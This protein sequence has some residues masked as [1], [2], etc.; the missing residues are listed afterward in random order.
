MTV[1][2]ASLKG[3]SSQK[4]TIVCIVVLFVSIF[5]NNFLVW[6]EYFCK[7]AAAAQGKSNNNPYLVSKI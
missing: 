2:N 6:Q 4:E 1:K 5:H 7:Q 3:N